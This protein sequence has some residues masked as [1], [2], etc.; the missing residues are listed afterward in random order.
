MTP[1]HR[2]TEQV[3]MLRLRSAARI[4]RAEAHDKLDTARK[5]GTANDIAR[6]RQEADDADALYEDIMES[7]AGWG[8][9]DG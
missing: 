6:A 2:I 9:P 5:A 8:H 3:D 4:L 1:F 7:T